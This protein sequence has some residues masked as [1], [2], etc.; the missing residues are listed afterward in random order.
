MRNLLIHY[1]LIS[2]LWSSTNKCKRHCIDTR[3]LSLHADIN[4]CASSPCKNGGTCIDGINSFQ[5]FCPDG[6][7]GSLCDVGECVCVCV[8][9]KGPALRHEQQC[10]AYIFWGGASSPAAC[11]SVRWE[12]SQQRRGMISSLRILAKTEQRQTC[13]KLKPVEKFGKRGTWCTKSVSQQR[14]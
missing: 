10:M 1:L 3:N 6:W 11:E 12:N 5:C 8:R 2:I 9:L 4:D 7:E 14:P 13:F